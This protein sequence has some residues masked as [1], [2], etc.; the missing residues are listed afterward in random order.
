MHLNALMRCACSVLRKQQEA[1]EAASHAEERAEI[2]GHAIVFLGSLSMSKEW[3]SLFKNEERVLC[4]NATCKMHAWTC[5]V[6]AWP[7]LA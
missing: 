4:N 6:E 3:G 5:M 2:S 7:P 1:G